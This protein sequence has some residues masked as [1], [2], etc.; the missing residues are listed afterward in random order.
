[1]IYTHVLNQGG[2]G[3]LG[4]LDDLQEMVVTSWEWLE[5]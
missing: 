5:A 4:P 2:R 1:M 3:V